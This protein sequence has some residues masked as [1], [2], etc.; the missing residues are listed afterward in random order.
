MPQ[1]KAR[2]TFPGVR[3]GLTNFD[4]LW[5]RFDR[6]GQTR[7]GPVTSKEPQ[8][9]ARSTF[10]GVRRG[11]TNFDQLWP[12]LTRVD[13]VW[14]RFDQA[15]DQT[16]SWIGLTTPIT[17]TWDTSRAL[18]RYFTGRKQTKNERVMGKTVKIGLTFSQILLSVVDKTTYLRGNICT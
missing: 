12:S 9:R 11:S 4:Q 3:G 6:A 18:I 10:P 7:Q 5:L 17:I 8:N 15:V 2:S 1:N 14:P 16:K 13:Q